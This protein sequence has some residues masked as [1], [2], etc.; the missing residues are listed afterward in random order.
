MRNNQTQSTYQNQNSQSNSPLNLN[1][2]VITHW[3]CNHVLN[4]IA[5]IEAYLSSIKPH[6]LLL[7]ETKNTEEEANLK[8][9][10][11]K[12]NTINKCRSLGN[13]GG[14]SLLVHNSICFEEV[15]YLKA[16]KEEIIG[17]NLKHKDKVISVIGWYNPPYNSKTNRNPINIETLNLIN[18]NT[19]NYI[20]VGDLN[21]RDSSFGCIGNNK[22]GL[23]LQNFLIEHE[24]VI[25]NHPKNYTYHKYNS[26]YK[27]LLDIAIGSPLIASTTKY[28]DIEDDSLLKSDHLPI[29]IQIDLAINKSP[30]STKDPQRLNYNKADW[31]NY[32]SLLTGL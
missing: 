32:K 22:N 1:Q 14:V 20:L 10:F 28:C 3:N 16:L 12:Y 29:K 7:N 17:I 5:Q 30:Q 15:D 11:P 13:G 19:S 9:R 18:N 26:D 25:L 23:L 6:I 27:E 2:I 4:K 21:S 24:A 8:L 31:S